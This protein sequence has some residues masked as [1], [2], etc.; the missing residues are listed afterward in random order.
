[1]IINKSVL[2]AGEASVVL[3]MPVQKVYKLIKNG[4]LL[5]YKD[6]FS[7]AWK[8]PEQSIL[9]YQEKRLNSKR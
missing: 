2:Y 7:K 3:N 8:I 6:D 4:V 1:M 9:D 5:A